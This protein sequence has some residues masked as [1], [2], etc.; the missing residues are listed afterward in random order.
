[1]IISRGMLPRNSV[2]QNGM[3]S[4]ADL[5]QLRRDSTNLSKDQ[6]I[7]EKYFKLEDTGTNRLESLW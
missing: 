3:P 5:G 2:E 7:R 6:L 1:M 4:A